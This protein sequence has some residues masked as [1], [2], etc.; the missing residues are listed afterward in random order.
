MFFCFHLLFVLP[1]SFSLHLSV[2]F[3]YKYMASATR[4][5]AGFSAPAGPVGMVLLQQARYPIEEAD[6]NLQLK[7]KRN[8]T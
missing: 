2:I 1:S 4:S 8:S 7:M 3:I 6:K 5:R